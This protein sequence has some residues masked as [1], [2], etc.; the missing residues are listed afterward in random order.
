LEYAVARALLAAVDYIPLRTATRIAEFLAD[1]WYAFD[2]PRR[3]TAQENILRSGIR[4]DSAAASRLARAS[5][6]HFG[7]MVLETLKS[8]TAIGDWSRH[9]TLRFSAD[10]DRALNEPGRGVILA[11]GHLGNWDVAGRFLS[12]IKPV[13]G[14]ARPMNNPYIDR[15][16]ARRGAGTRLELIPKRA[17]DAG[18]FLSV[19]KE[20]KILVFMIDQHARQK[21][22]MVDFFGAPASTHTAVALLHLVSRLPL[23]FGYCRRTGPLQYELVAQTRIVRKPTGNKE[24]DIRAILEAL[25]REL[26]AAVRLCPEQYLWAHRRWRDAPR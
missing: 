8:S 12:R 22:M 23:V 15:L 17:D 19:L 13:V 4:S 26:E 16:M 7:V 3:R 2:V 1:L 24:E 14:I 9:V 10:V 18:R 21:G 25:N 11:C 6:R 5:V 20:G